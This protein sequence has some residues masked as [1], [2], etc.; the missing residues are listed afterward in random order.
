MTDDTAIRPLWRFRLPQRSP[1]PSP[2]VGQV[3]DEPTRTRTTPNCQEERMVMGLSGW[4]WHRAGGPPVS[5]VADRPPC[6]AAQHEGGMAEC[7]AEP[8]GASG[9]PTVKMQRKNITYHRGIYLRAP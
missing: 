7:P 3:S 6:A 8:L 2:R 9:L 1:S 4:H 5:T